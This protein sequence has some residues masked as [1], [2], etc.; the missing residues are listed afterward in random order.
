MVELGRRVCRG[1]LREGV[2]EA[3]L[4]YMLRGQRIFVFERH[5]GDIAG[6]SRDFIFVFIFSL[7]RY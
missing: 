2:G 1:S 6:R 5:S 4:Y 7:Y 3:G